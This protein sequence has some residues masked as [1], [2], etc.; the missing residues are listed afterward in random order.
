MKSRAMVVH[1]T[2][3]KI[4]NFATF[5]VENW[6]WCYT[7]ITQDALHLFKMEMEHRKRGGKAEKRF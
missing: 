3:I 2:E 7:A 5:R 1:S 4:Q 6:R